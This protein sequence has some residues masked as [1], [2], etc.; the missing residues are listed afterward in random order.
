MQPGNSGGKLGITADLLDLKKDLKDKRAG[1][2]V[3]RY[4]A[5][6]ILIQPV[7]RHDAI[8]QYESKVPAQKVFTIAQKAVIR[9]APNKLFTLI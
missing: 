7:I 8:H 1:V 4:R 9:F 6:V 3:I 5:F 2:F